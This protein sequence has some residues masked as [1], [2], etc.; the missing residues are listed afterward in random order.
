MSPKA[1][2]IL[3]GVV[4]VAAVVAGLIRWSRLRFHEAPAP[5]PAAQPATVQVAEDAEPK[6]LCPQERGKVVKT[7]GVLELTVERNAD[8]LCAY[9]VRSSKG[10]KLAE[11]EGGLAVTAQF[12]DLDAD[13]ADELI[14]V[15]DSG[16]SG[17]HADTLVFTQRPEPHLI[18]KYDGCATR[19]EKAADGRRAL[20]TCALQMNMMD[21]VC[22]GCSPRPYIYYMLE[23][24]K[25]VRR[26]NLFT[27]AYDKR[28][29]AEQKDIR[30][31][32]AEAFLKSENKDDR[33]FWDA[34]TRSAVMRIAADYIY[35][36]REAKAKEVIEKYWPAWDRE[37]ILEDLR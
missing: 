6:S 21:G 9:E 14:V 29:V 12:A 32:D 26:N 28:I 27:S 36:G 23:S 18:D 7:Y 11:D 22:N 34:E 25:L 16:G 30:P 5:A 20:M 2:K 37:R 17:L 13:A 19:V 3:I 1:L 10:A 33:A 24:G 4:V 35:S 15:A 31:E 8:D